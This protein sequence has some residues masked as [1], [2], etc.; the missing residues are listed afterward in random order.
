M[1]RAMVGIS[2]AAFAVYIWGFVFWGASGLPYG[3]WKKV[4][5]E[6]AVGQ[7]LKEHFPTAGVYAIPGYGADEKDTAQR[8]E[9]GPVAFVYMTARDGR[10]MMDPS[11]MIGGLVLYFAVSAVMFAL[12]K[13]AN[14][15]PYR[16]RVGLCMLVGVAGALAITLGDVVW[17]QHD[18]GWKGWQAFYDVSSF[19][20][21]GLVISAFTAP[22]GEND[23]AATE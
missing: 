19:L 18:S 5:N 20:I 14:V 6:V 16:R 4:D 15:D 10:P 22:D 17:W 11:I 12:L 8:F 1:I 9:N 21:L 3:A 7:V 13:V 23:S 2:A